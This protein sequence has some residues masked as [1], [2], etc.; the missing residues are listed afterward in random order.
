MATERE[1]ERVTLQETA[2]MQHCSTS[3]TC[4]AQNRLQTAL[5]KDPASA[6]TATAWSA[7]TAAKL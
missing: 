7:V 1:E 4:A 6:S 3:N 5:Q 2:S